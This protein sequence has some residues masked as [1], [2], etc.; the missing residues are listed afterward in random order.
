MGRMQIGRVAVQASIPGA[1]NQLCSYPASHASHDMTGRRM[2][3]FRPLQ[4]TRCAAQARVR[5]PSARVCRLRTKL[6]LQ[7][8]APMRRS[9][10]EMRPCAVFHWQSPRHT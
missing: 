2:R 7:S 9:A 6:G 4:M 5:I 1:R 10:M 3:F 8:A